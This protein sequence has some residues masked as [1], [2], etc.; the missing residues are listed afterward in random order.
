VLEPRQAQRGR[1][2]TA[3]LVNPEPTAT[4]FAV[5]VKTVAVAVVLVLES[6]PGT[7]AGSVVPV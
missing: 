4:V 5:T 2:V 7:L 1:P 6:G 3:A